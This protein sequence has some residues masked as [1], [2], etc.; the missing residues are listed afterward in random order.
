ML[1]GPGSRTMD[2]T[3]LSTTTTS[4]AKT[5]TTAARTAD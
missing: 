3:A 2:M 1:Q 5:V 4:K